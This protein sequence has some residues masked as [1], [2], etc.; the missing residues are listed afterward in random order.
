MQL[1]SDKGLDKSQFFSVDTATSMEDWLSSLWKREPILLYDENRELTPEQVV[2]Q[3]LDELGREL[4][5]P[6]IN[7]FFIIKDYEGWDFDLYS[8]KEENAY[9]KNNEFYKLWTLTDDQYIVVP[10]EIHG[11][12]E[13]LTHDGIYDSHFFLEYEAG[14]WRLWL[15]NRP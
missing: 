5:K 11:K 6:D 9:L 13:G 10:R 2:E 12:Y 4:T 14:I 8:N 1:C 15:R 3:T 7:R